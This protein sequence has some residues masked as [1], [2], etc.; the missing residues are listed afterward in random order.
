MKLLQGAVSG[1]AT[2]PGPSTPALALKIEA[3]KSTQI[4]R[5]ELHGCNSPPKCALLASGARNEREAAKS[6]PQLFSDLPPTRLYFGLVRRLAVPVS[7]TPI[8]GSFVRYRCTEE[9]RRLGNAQVSHKYRRIKLN[10]NRYS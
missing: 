9:D 8:T 2:F 6:S 7:R 3:T 10:G 4:R 1:D 5:S